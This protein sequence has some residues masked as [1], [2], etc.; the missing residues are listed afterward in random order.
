MSLDVRFKI[1]DSE[2]R[3]CRNGKASWKLDHL[4]WSNDAKWRMTQPPLIMTARAGGTVFRE[5]PDLN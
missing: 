5:G 4:V 2:E 3:G 1:M